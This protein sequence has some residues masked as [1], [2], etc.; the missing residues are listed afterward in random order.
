MRSGWYWGLW[1]LWCTHCGS[2]PT[3]FATEV[4]RPPAITWDWWEGDHRPAADLNLLGRHRGCIVAK[5]TLPPWLHAESTRLGRLKAAADTPD[6]PTGIHT[7]TIHFD[8]PDGLEPQPIHVRLRV[9]QKPRPDAQ[10]RV[11]FIGIDGVR[12]SALAHVETPALNTLMQH[13]LWSFAA[14][15]QKDALPVSGPGWTSLLTGVQPS[16]HGVRGN[17]LRRNTLHYPSFLARARNHGLHTAAVV[18]WQPLISQ[19]LGREGSL[20]IALASDDD[21]V[22]KQAARL[23]TTN[24]EVLFVHFNDPDRI[25]HDSGFEDNNPAYLQALTHTNRRIDTLLDALTQRLTTTNE[26]WLVVVASDHGGSGRRHDL[27]I[28]ACQKT[29][30][31]F[32]AFGLPRGRL[33]ADISQVD[34]HPTILAFLG[35]A[36]LQDWGL[37]GSAKH[38]FLGATTEPAWH[39]IFRDP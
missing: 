33:P 34:A 37:D 28:P 11:M 2:L 18:N 10:R 35:I 6:L 26:H 16:K 12:T 23:L 20:E 29:L 7:A 1:A 21:G 25:G 17:D 15:T 32:S 19:W 38:I 22:A 27:R 14:N 31:V 30:L 3:E 5:H 8:C 13:G 9:W 4:L 39:E 36:I 24:T